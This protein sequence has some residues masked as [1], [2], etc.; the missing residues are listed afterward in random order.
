LKIGKLCKL[1]SEKEIEEVK[2]NLVHRNEGSLACRASPSH[3]TSRRCPPVYSG[4]GVMTG[5][6]RRDKH[7][8]RENGCIFHTAKGAHHS[9]TVSRANNR[10]RTGAARARLFLA[11]SC[12]L[13]APESSIHTL[14]RASLVPEARG[15]HADAAP[16]VGVVERRG[17]RGPLRELRLLLRHGVLRLA[18][19]L[20]RAGCRGQHP[21]GLR[22]RR[23]H[24]A[25]AGARRLA[26]AHGEWSRSGGAAAAAAGPGC[27]R[28]WGAAAG[29]APPVRVRANGR[30]YRRAAGGVHVLRGARGEEWSGERGR[31]AAARQ[32]LAVRGLPGRRAGRRDGAA[33]AGVPPP[34]SRRLRRRLV[35][36]SPD[37]PALPLPAL[38][39]E[40]RQHKAGRRGRRGVIHRRVAA[41]VSVTHSSILRSWPAHW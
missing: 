17:R 35:A 26:R 9:E 38:P 25:P 37:V 5:C 20:H 19:A 11:R 6:G 32:L 34:V 14:G 24:A 27:C 40:R 16:E 12:P 1:K 13:A 31:Q 41:G 22:H 39:E 30:R 15:R 36:R 2:L 28:S 3:R 33:A 21:E 18:A 23:R 4:Q 7:A 29:G 10:R 8:R